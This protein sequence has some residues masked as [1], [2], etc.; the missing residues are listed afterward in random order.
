MPP[1]AP[2]TPSPRDSAHL[3][4]LRTSSLPPRARVKVHSVDDEVLELPPV[5]SK[6]AL[7]LMIQLLTDVD[8]DEC[9]AH[10]ENA[11]FVCDLAQVYRAN[12]RWERAFGRPGGP[13]RRVEPFFGASLKV[14]IL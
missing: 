6:S 7:D 10:G 3:P 13:V 5:H 11:F 4:V 8:I 14:L 2:P 9:E 1:T 12:E